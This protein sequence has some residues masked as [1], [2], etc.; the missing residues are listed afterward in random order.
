MLYRS[1]FIV[2]KDGFHTLKSAEIISVSFGLL[3]YSGCSYMNL[4]CNLHCLNSTSFSFCLHNM[5]QHL[6]EYF[7]KYVEI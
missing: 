4:N 6:Q 5:T 7:V 1:F 2:I 3:N